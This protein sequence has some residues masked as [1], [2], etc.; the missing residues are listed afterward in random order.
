MVFQWL[1]CWRASQWGRSL[2]VW[3]LL[4][5][6]VSFPSF[7]FVK[8]LLS[9]GVRDSQEGGVPPPVLGY[10]LAVEYPYRYSQT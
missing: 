9:W 3:L 5:L 4:L 1:L 2:S 10:A 6:V 8:G 7:S